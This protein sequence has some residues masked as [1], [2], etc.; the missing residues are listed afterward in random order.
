[1]NI[2]DIYVPMLKIAWTKRKLNRIFLTEFPGKSKAKEDVDLHYFIESQTILQTE[3]NVLVVK[4]SEILLQFGY[5][6]LF[7]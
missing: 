5:I 7:S 3:S 1:M 6:V 4:Y 2:L